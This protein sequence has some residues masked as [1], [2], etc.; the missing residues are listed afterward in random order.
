MNVISQQPLATPRIEEDETLDEDKVQEEELH[1][2][3]SR[4]E[5]R[6]FPPRINFEAKPATRVGW[7]EEEKKKFT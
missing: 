7:V 2:A 3:G 4:Y 1:Y 5:Q 6:R